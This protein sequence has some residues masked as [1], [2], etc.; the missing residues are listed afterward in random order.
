MLREEEN[1]G[2][3]TLLWNVVVEVGSGLKVGILRTED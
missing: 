1:D 3:E 2:L